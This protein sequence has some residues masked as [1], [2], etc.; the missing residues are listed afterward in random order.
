M[1]KSPFPFQHLARYFFCKKKCFVKSEAS[2]ILI[3]PKCSQLWKCKIC[4][5]VIFFGVI[6]KVYAYY[7]EIDLG[8]KIIDKFCEIDFSNVNCLKMEQKQC[9]LFSPHIGLSFTSRPKVH[10]KIC[11][12][13]LTSTWKSVKKRKKFVQ[14]GVIFKSWN[15]FL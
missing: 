13:N 7:Y 1:F 6:K 10:A 2:L 14:F 5:E 15:F 11:V 3:T 12:K 8:V 9:F 4:A